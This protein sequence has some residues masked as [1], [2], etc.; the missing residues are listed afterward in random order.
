MQDSKNESGKREKM[1]VQNDVL[2]DNNKQR[3]S[4]RSILKWFADEIYRNERRRKKKKKVPTTSYRN[5]YQY[6]R[7]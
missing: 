4:I 3:K 2:D 7:T 5:I 1:G 6:V